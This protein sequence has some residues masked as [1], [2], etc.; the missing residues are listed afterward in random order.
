VVIDIAPPF[1]GTIL[2]GTGSFLKVLME[3]SMLDKPY[4][5][6]REPDRSAAG[7]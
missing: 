6:E 3:P 4:V 2:G 5:E 1:R 7:H